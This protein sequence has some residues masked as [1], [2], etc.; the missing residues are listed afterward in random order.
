LK[1][2]RLSGV[3]SAALAYRVFPRSDDRQA[4]IIVEYWCYYVFN[5]YTIK[6]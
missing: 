3:A 2:C 6:E 5:A 4:E 1:V